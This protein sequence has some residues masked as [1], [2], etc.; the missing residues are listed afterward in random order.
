VPFRL[1]GQPVWVR[2]GARV[3]EIYDRQYQLV[4]THS[5][6]GG[7]GDRL[8]HLDHLPPE[9]VPGLV[10]SREDVRLRAAAI[11]PATAQLVGQVLDHRPEDRLRSAGRLLRLAARSSPDRLERACA[12]A[13][14]F[15]SADYLTV[16]R[17]L[18]EGLDRQPLATAAPPVTAAP[19]RPYAFVRGAAEF[20]A[21]LV[22]GGR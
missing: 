7:A 5:R 8:T 19:P 2:G 9:K 17:I 15:E 6:A 1:V 14:A 4:A 13:L 22:G 21:S 20:V 3:V 16:R 11:G 18:A 10:L 12:R